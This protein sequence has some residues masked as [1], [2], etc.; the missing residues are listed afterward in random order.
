ME[1]QL[2]SPEHEAFRIQVAAVVAQQAAVTE[3]EIRLHAILGQIE[4]MVERLKVA[5]GHLNRREAILREREVLLNRTYEGLAQKLTRLVEHRQTLLEVA[6]NLI[7]ED[8]L[9]Q[10]RASLDR[11]TL[12][13]H[14]A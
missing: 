3:E 9:T 5:E 14:A 7:E 8:P 13:L 6:Q 4:S 11:P 1:P 10:L 2:T 12:R